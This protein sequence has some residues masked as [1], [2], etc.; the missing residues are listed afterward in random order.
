M[1]YTRVEEEEIK[2][3]RKSLKNQKKTVCWLELIV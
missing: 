2:S 3:W 1:R